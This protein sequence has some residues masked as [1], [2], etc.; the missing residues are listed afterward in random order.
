MEDKLSANE[1]LGES[2]MSTVFSLPKDA[3]EKQFSTLKWLR[4]RLEHDFYEYEAG[5]FFFFSSFFFAVFETFL[6]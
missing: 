2:I 1:R 4:G 5:N 6:Q 3:Q